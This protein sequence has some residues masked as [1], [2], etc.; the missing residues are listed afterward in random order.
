MEATKR[1]PRPKLSGKDG[2]AF[3]ILA[4]A[5]GAAIK[6]KWSEAEIEAV[7]KDAKS[8]NYDHLLQ[9]MFKFFDVR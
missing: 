4:S 1:K 9:T 6:A 2:N 3:F 7:M 5:R 8:G